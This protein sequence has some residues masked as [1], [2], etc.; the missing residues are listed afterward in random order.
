MGNHMIKFSVII[1]TVVLVQ[2]RTSKKQGPSDCYKSYQDTI[3]LTNVTNN[4][5]Q[6]DGQYKNITENKEN[7]S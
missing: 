7:K 3:N 2:Q 4:S 1:P 5:L 6:T